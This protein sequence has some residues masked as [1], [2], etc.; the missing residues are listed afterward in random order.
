MIVYGSARNPERWPE[1]ARITPVV[2]KTI[3]LTLR[4]HREMDR[5]GF[6]AEMDA[7]VADGITFFQRRTS[8]ADAEK[9]HSGTVP[10]A[11]AGIKVWREVATAVP[12]GVPAEGVLSVSP[13]AIRNTHSESAFQ[14]EGGG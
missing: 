5:F 14:K 6:G 3:K 2:P 4:P 12:K 8:R 13:G 1:R 7:V 10:H 9:W 11:D